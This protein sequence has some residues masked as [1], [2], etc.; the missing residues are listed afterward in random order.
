MLKERLTPLV[1]QTFASRGR[2]KPGSLLILSMGRVMEGN[3]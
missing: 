3:F 2:S 1:V